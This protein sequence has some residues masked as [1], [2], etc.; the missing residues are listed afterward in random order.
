MTTINIIQQLNIFTIRGFCDCG[1]CDCEHSQK[2]SLTNRSHYTLY[3]VYCIQCMAIL[4][5][6]TASIKCVVVRMLTLGIDMT[7]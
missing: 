7:T 4:R 3:T 6:K 5:V 1:F 2:D